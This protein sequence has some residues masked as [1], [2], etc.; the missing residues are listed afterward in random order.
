MSIICN[1]AVLRF[2]PYPE[3]GEFANLGIVMICNNGQFLEMIETRTRKRVTNFFDKLDPAIF[4]SA[5]Q[6]FAKEIHRVAELANNHPHDV[7][8]QLGL[9]KHLTAPSETM[10]RFSKPGTI[11]TSDPQA[12]LSELFNRYVCHEFAHREDTETKLKRSINNLLRTNFSDRTYREEKLGDELY[13][14]TFPFVWHS[15]GITAQAIR[16]L[17]FDLDDTKSIIDK[18]DRWIMQMNRLAKHGGIPSDTV[19]ICKEP[20]G[21][22]ADHQKIYREIT[23]ELRSANQIRVIPYET[24]PNQMSGLLAQANYH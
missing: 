11:A 19:F 5:R 1:Y 2:Q 8:F 15:G 24:P 18:G 20:K 9:F 23:S 22:N 14:V 4:T 10:F 13:H 17:S 3:T 16:P 12:T 21:N 7:A 6:A